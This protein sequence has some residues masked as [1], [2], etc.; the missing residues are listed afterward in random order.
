MPSSC[1]VFFEL[2]HFKWNHHL[3]PFAVE[4]LPH[5]LYH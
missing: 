3:G 2:M 4:N 1:Y 5:K